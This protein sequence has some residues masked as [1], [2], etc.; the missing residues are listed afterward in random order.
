M[1]TRRNFLRGAGSF[2][3]VFLL[4]EGVLGAGR[5]K[6]RAR[7]RGTAKRRRGVKGSRVRNNIRVTDAG[8]LGGSKLYEDVIAYYNLGE[9]RTAT[10]VDLKTSQWLADQLR[11]AGLKATF[12]SF[13]LRQFFIHHTRLTIGDRTIRA[14]PLWFPRA[15]D[16][17]PINGALALFDKNTPAQVRD[18]IALTTFPSDSRWPPSSSKTEVINTA[19]KAGARAV[20]AI[21]EGDTKE[22]VALNSPAGA[23]PWPIPVVLAGPRDEV[24]LM[25]AARGAYAGTLLVEGSDETDARARNVIARLDRG[26]ELIVVST[27]QSGWFR[28]AAERGPGVALFLGLARWAS[29]RASGSSF[30][31]VSTSGHEVGAL[32][33]RAF[34]KDLAPAP[35]NVK[36]WIHLGAGIAAFKWEE[37][38]NGLRR[39]QEPDSR[40]TL[41]TSRDLVPILTDAFAGVAGMTPNT[42]RAVG[43]F[44]QLIKAGYHTFGIAAAHQF[45]HT[46]ADS[47]EMTGPEILE[48][49]GRSI[50]QALESIESRL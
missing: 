50:V 8:P 10:E 11:A 6:K 39:L 45:H 14:F 33:M 28:C 27:P 7:V 38:A 5:N 30:L 48:P 44:E 36:C 19:A 2:V 35:D 22:I 47:P 18:K 12:Q 34:L 49:V 23:E 17:G 42:D 37:G 40:R 43:E 46:P 9:H 4:G 3:G 25:A 15:T 26:K 21:T 16:A 20:V 41:M 1:I 13:A 29:R 31:F 32:G 24:A